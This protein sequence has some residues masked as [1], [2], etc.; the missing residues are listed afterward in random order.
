MSTIPFTAGRQGGADRAWPP[1]A[2]GTHEVSKE[3]IHHRQVA[4]AL[5]KP[6]FHEPFFCGRYSFSPYQGCGHGCLYCDGRAE[7]YYVEGDFEHDIVA[8]TNVPSL[9]AEELGK[10]RE[11]GAVAIGSGVSDVYQPVEGK[12]RLTRACAE[13]L[14]ERGLPVVLATKSSL[15]ERDI[16][17]WERVVADGGFTLLMTVVTTDEKLRTDVEPGASTI[18]SRLDTLRRFK[19]AGASV[20]VLAMP[21]LPGLSDGEAD[22]RR[23]YRAVADAGADCVMPGNLTLRPGRQK[24]LFFDYIRRR[25]PELESGYARLFAE[26]RQSGNTIASYR[27]DLYPIFDR[28]REEVGLPAHVPHRAFAGRIPKPDEIYLLLCHM[29]EIYSHRGVDTR[30]LSAS[31]ERYR[32]WLDEKRRFFNRR[33]SL[34]CEWVSEQF[35]VALEQEDDAGVLFD[36]PRL[37]AF[38]RQV[39]GGKV[40]DYTRLELAG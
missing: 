28:L 29:S 36:N 37:T 24:D 17:I 15:V 39:V 16:D 31:L 35:T 34:G 38:V 32:G 3:A 11:P 14:A 27:G 7:K 8:R 9:L 2:G 6:R 19:A 18:R 13:V 23:L 21:V 12:L 40:F 4:K 10:L 30:R 33:R 1:A 20:G 22:M 26:E 25:H 5:R